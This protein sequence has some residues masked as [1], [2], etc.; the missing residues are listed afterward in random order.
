[1]DCT[2][3][4]RPLSFRKTAIALTT[5]GAALAAMAAFPAAAQQASTI[6]FKGAQACAHITDPTE[7]SKCEVRESQ[8]RTDSANKRSARADDEGK[9]LALI[10]SDLEHS[11]PKTANLQAMP[12]KGQACQTARELKLIA[13]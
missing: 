6:N 1:M 5:T 10:V 13:G 4:Y 3:L 9:C 2:M 8:R 11:G 7:G 12:P